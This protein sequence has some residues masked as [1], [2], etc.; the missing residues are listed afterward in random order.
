MLSLAVQHLLDSHSTSILKACRKVRTEALQA[1]YADRVF[2][3][4]PLAGLPRGI[5]PRVQLSRVEL[6]WIRT[7]HVPINHIHVPTII[8]PLSFF[9]TAGCR[10]RR[11]ILDIRLSDQSIPA[12]VQLVRNTTILGAIAALNIAQEIEIKLTHQQTDC[13]ARLDDVMASIAIARGWRSHRKVFDDGNGDQ[14]FGLRDGNGLWH[15]C[16]YLRPDA[17]LIGALENLST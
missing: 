5:S 2:Y 14:D 13:G 3:Y 12:V 15:W 1:L 16:W 7:I 17:A 4:K 11:L 6:L 10:L 9:S 8:Q